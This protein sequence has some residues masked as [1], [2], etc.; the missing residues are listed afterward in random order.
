MQGD[1]SCR[2]RHERPIDIRAEW[3][4]IAFS[5]A[6]TPMADVEAQEAWLSMHPRKTTLPSGVPQCS[7]RIYPKDSNTLSPEAQR[8]FSSGGTVFAPL[9]SI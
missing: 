5:V 9:G 6:I 2:S 8:G 1:R 4:P 7:E 3:V